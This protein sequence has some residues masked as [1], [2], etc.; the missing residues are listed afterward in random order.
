MVTKNT[1]TADEAKKQ[2]ETQSTWETILN[3]LLDRSG[4]WSR[5]NGGSSGPKPH[6]AELELPEDDEPRKES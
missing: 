3:K 4:M 1:P 2:Q 5:G 6:L